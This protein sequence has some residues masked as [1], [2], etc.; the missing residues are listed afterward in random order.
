MWMRTAANA[1]IAN[2]IRVPGGPALFKSGVFL[3]EGCG[4]IKPSEGGWTLAK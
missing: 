3:L 1:A 2:A 4:A